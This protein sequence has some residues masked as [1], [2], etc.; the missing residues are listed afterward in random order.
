MSRGRFCTQRYASNVN[1][2]DISTKTELQ[3]KKVL[4]EEQEED[5]M[6]GVD[7]ISTTFADA[8]DREAFGT[9]LKAARTEA[10]YTLEEMGQAMRPEKPFATSNVARIEAGGSVSMNQISLYLSV[11][12]LKPVVSL[13]PLEQV[14][15]STA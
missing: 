4:Y 14:N 11:L 13:Q 10:G 5:N 9:M 6:E 1:Y 7:R 12:G 3:D 15:P 8:T 2:I